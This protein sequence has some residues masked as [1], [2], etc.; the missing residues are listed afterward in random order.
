[1]VVLSASK[2]NRAKEENREWWWQGE[3]RSVCFLLNWTAAGDF[4]A[5]PNSDRNLDNLQN[6]HFLRPIRDLRL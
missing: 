1:M 3:E 6:H 5:C 2:K 4:C